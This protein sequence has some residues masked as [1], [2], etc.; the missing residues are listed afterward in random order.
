MKTLFTSFLLCLL[1]TSCKK[2]D[3]ITA[4]VTNLPP[5]VFKASFDGIEKTFNLPESYS[6][7][8]NGTYVLKILAEK[9]INNDSSILIKFTLPDITKTNTASYTKLFNNM[10]WAD[11]FMELGSKPGGGQYSSGTPIQSGQLTIKGHDA[12]YVDGNF[13][14]VFFTYD[15][16]GMKKDEVHVT[17]GSFTNLKI[18]RQY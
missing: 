17:N 3:E 14:F 2:N 6:F 8:D 1:F 15:K 7:L 12:N 5:T 18:I 10:F 13:S 9:T 16:W 4:P 11:A